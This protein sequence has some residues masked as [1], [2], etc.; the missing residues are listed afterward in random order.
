MR[1][2]LAVLVTTAAFLVPAAAASADQ[3][4]ASCNNG[5]GGN[6]SLTG[7]TNNGKGQGGGECRS[8]STGGTY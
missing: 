4:N 2:T 5:K 1:R 7:H 3:T 8:G 6:Y